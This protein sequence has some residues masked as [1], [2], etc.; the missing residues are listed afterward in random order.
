V[1]PLLAVFLAFLWVPVTSPAG[2]QTGAR[3]FLA[4]SMKVAEARTRRA[5]GAAGPTITRLGHISRIAGAI[6]D[7]T[8]RDCILVGERDPSL[9]ELHLD[10][11]VVF[12]RGVFLYD[13]KEAP[14]VTIDPAGH[15]PRHSA[16]RVRYFGHVENTRVGLVF[17]ESDYLMKRIGLG[18]QPARVRG[19]RT[20]FE[21]AVEEARQAGWRRTEVNSRFWYYPTVARVISVGNGILL[22]RCEL[23]VLTEILSAKVEG[24]PVANLAAF[25]HRPSE[26][27][28]QSFT[29]SLDELAREWPVIARLRSLTALSAVSRGLARTDVL[30]DLGYWLRE[31][32]VPRVETPTRVDVLRNAQADLNFEVYGG[33]HLQALSVRLKEGDLTA[34]SEAVLR[35]RPSPEAL[36]WSVVLTPEKELVVPGLLDRIEASAAV[37]AYARADYLFRAKQYDLAI[38]CWRQVLRTYPQMGEVY[39]RIGLAFERKG[40][41]ACA[42]DYYTKA[43]E[44]DPFM[45]NLGPPGGPGR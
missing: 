4:F 43:I 39:Y 6:V 21:L 45:R 13:D 10:D 30:P 38:A 15:D 17:F 1:R 35:A 8:T 14:G 44:L 41:L 40:L 29:A 25:C 23:A 31:Y 27:F 9:P 33:V 34:F 3:T 36:T 22:D 28:A 20:Y 2:E 11:F 7:P 37:E 19:L 16:Q 26:L 18:L 24:Q 5:G 42:A 32:R 12:L